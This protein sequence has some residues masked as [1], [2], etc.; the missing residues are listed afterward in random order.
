MPRVHR[1]RW[2]DVGGA[3]RP[4]TFAQ[5]P[6]CRA[7]SAGAQVGSALTPVLI[8]RY[9]I[10]K[11]MKGVFIVGAAAL[12]VPFVMH[13]VREPKQ[14]GEAPP[15]PVRRAL[16][17]RRCQRGASCSAPSTPYSACVPQQP[18]RLFA[19][20]LSLRGALPGACADLA[21]VAGKPPTPT[22]ITFEGQVQLVAFCVFE[23]VV[24]VFW[25]S[26]M[27]MRAHYVPE[28]LRSTIINCFRIP[29]NLF[30]CIILYNVRKALACSFA[31]LLAGGDGA[32]CT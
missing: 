32:L 27:T 28:E 18:V 6:R 7:D 5:L 4:G 30:V 23:V 25:P 26:M 10:E 1:A 22:G 19:Q 9:K 13:F 31:F 15:A 16:A 11:Y 17:A 20:P 8:K 29:L 3:W 12:S 24:G 14:Q 2:C 21:L